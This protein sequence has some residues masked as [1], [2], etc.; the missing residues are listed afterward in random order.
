MEFPFSFLFYNLRTLSSFRVQ[1]KYYLLTKD[2]PDVAMQLFIV[3]F[4]FS[5]SFHLKLF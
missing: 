4:V 5:E 1:L 2:F 3:C